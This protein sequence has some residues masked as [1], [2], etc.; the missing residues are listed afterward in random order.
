M[1]LH[2]FNILS[3]AVGERKV[4]LEEQQILCYAA[5]TSMFTEFSLGWCWQKQFNNLRF[6]LMKVITFFL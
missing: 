6:Q 5:D 2:L 1:S 3:V 4:C